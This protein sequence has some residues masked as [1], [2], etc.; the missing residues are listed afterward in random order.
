MIGLIN[1]FSRH[2]CIVGQ[3][4]ISPQHVVS[5]VLQ[6]VC[7]GCFVCDENVASSVMIWFAV[8]VFV[9]LLW[10]PPSEVRLYFAP[11]E[12]QHFSPSRWGESQ[13]SIFVV[14][15]PRRYQPNVSRLTFVHRRPY[16]MGLLVAGVTGH[17]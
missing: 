2:G 9:V 1:C 14:W 6:P 12:V 11:S 10:F 5:V 4:C 3:H 7:E 17:E 15:R 16:R 8:L 13:L